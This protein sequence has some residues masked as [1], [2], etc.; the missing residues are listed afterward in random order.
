[1]HIYLV[2]E[3]EN[4]QGSEPGESPGKQEADHTQPH[5]LSGYG[6]ARLCFCFALLPF[7]SVGFLA[8]DL[9]PDD[10]RATLI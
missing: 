8:G 9:S 4:G 6:Y 3:G 1:M 7:F 10:G 5:S 2:N